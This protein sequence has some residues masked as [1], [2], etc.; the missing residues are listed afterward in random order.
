MPCLITKKQEWTL[1]L[2]L[3]AKLHDFNSFVT[4]TYSDDNRPDNHSVSKRELQLFNKRLRK[5]L[6][7]SYKYYAVGEY[8]EKN[9]REH[10]HLILFGF[11]AF[12]AHHVVTAW[13]KYCHVLKEYIP[14]GRVQVDMLKRGGSQYVSGYVTKKLINQRLEKDPDNKD[15]YIDGRHVEFSLMSP[16]RS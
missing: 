2:E 14:I 9:G 11:P 16:N 4:L 6:E 7:Y 13:S 15:Y 10:Y 8:G 3:E 5:S 1:R 12:D